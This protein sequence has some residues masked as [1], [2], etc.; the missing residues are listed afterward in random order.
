MKVLFKKC[1]PNKYYGVPG[2]S[3]KDFPSVSVKILYKEHEGDKFLWDDFLYSDCS[4]TKDND[5]TTTFHMR[6]NF[7]PKEIKD[8]LERIYAIQRVSPFD[9]TKWDTAVETYLPIAKS[10][11]WDIDSIDFQKELW[12]TSEVLEQCLTHTDAEVFYRYQ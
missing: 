1:I 6:F 3:M 7:K 8:F 12:W 11:G 5:G 4:T 10:S 9:K 2:T